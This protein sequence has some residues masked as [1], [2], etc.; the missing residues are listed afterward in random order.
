MFQAPWPST[1]SSL[2]HWSVAVVASS[3]SWR[4]ASLKPYSTGRRT[5]NLL[6]KPCSSITFPR[7]TR[8]KASRAS[9][10]K[11][12]QIVKLAGL[13][14]FA[15]LDFG[16]AAWRKY[17]DKDAGISVIAHI[18]GTLTGFLVGFTLLVDEREEWREKMLKFVCW[19][20]YSLGN[21]PGSSA[22]D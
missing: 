14:L 21:G 17:Q 19:T 15:A 2:A 6:Q 9:S 3:A 12:Y 7:F 11:M 1:V 18:F 16:S 5:V 13:L 4:P 10:G 8:R 20:G 22:S